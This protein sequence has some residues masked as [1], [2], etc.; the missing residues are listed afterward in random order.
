MEDAK[1]KVKDELLINRLKIVERD[2]GGTSMDI[3][4]MTDFATP[5]EKQKYITYFLELVKTDAGAAFADAEA[6]YNVIPRIWMGPRGKERSMRAKDQ[7]GYY[8]VENH[9]AIDAIKEAIKTGRLHNGVASIALHI[10]NYSNDRDWI[11]QNEKMQDVLVNTDS[12]FWDL[13]RPELIKAWGAEEGKCQ[14]DK[15]IKGADRVRAEASVAAS[16]GAAGGAG[17]GASA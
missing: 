15:I 13:L 17:A 10:T 12:T 8:I 4:F 16:T 2:S 5:T 6:F 7:Y 1:A 9:G 3:R 11:G 14:V